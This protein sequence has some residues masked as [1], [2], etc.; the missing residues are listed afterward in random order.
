ME[1]FREGTAFPAAIFFSV[2]NG[3]KTVLIFDSV[4]IGKLFS[5]DICSP[6]QVTLDF[7]A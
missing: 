2:H 1:L 7:L 3:A 5:V 6:E 4:D